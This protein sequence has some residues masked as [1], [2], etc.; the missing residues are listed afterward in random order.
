MEKKYIVRLSDQERETCKKVILKL[1]GTNE[2][3]AAKLSQ[4]LQYT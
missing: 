3:Q 4:L 2:K 1:K